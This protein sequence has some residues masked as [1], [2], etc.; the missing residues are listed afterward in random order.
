MVPEPAPVW[1]ALEGHDLL[2]YA[3]ARLLLLTD[4]YAVPETVNAGWD[5]YAKGL[6]RP[7]KPHRDKWDTA[8]AYAVG[9]YPLEM[10]DL[11]REG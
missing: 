5:C 11:M 1:R 6:W 8:W 2:A 10:A 3:L 9:Q 7:G 4:P